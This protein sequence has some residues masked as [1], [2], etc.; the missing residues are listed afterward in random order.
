MDKFLIIVGGVLLAAIVTFFAPLL[1]VVLGA[2]SGWVVGMFFPETILGFL[3]QIGITGL[4]VWE[5]GA[6]LGFLGGFFRYIPV[7]SK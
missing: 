7:S 4:E 5:V 6:S 3:E 1:M 2:F